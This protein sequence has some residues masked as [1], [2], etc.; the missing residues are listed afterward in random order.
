MIARLTGKLVHKSLE[1]IIVDVGGVGYRLFVPLSTYYELPEEGNAVTINT[2]LNV[3]D[4]ALLLFGFNSL[5]EKEIF[6]KLVSVS[7]IGPK[8]GLAILSGISPAELVNAIE[9]KDI[10]KLTSIPGVGK[11]TA[12]RLFLEL[13][14]KVKGLELAGKVEGVSDM[15]PQDKIYDDVLSALI[16]FG[17]KKNVA[18]NAL[19][20]AIKVCDDEETIET[21]LKMTLNILSK[22]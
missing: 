11:K 5:D 8:L 9:H 10:P 12:E 14:D 3:R 6:L 17:Y 18:E 13:G 16:N 7:G 21:L 22:A 4:D 20:K 2:Y 19:K 15:L 1:Y